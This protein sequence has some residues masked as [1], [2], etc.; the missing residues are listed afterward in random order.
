MGPPVN[1]YIYIYNMLAQ[2]GI[3]ICKALICAAVTRKSDSLCINSY[4]HCV[5]VVS[6]AIEGFMRHLHIPRVGTMH[7]LNSQFARPSVAELSLT[8]GDRLG[9]KKPDTCSQ[10]VVVVVVAALGVVVVVVCWNRHV[11]VNNAW[12]LPLRW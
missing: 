7:N 2:H 4:C 6:I 12:L 5:A 9:S 1:I 10:C 3:L 8:N 11:A